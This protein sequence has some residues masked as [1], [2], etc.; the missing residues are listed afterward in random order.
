MLKENETSLGTS[1]FSLRF[2][3]NTM[4]ESF[5]VFF[6]V[7]LGGVIFSLKSLSLVILRLCIDFQFHMNPGT[8]KKV[9]WW[10]VLGGLN[11]NLLFCFGQNLFP[12][13][14]RFGFGPS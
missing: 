11:V 13:N 6:C 3:F 2:D 14:F 12:Q 7:F 1:V 9:F 4:D 8:S 5:S 10:W